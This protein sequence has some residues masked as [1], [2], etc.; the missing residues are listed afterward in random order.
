MTKIHETDKPMTHTNNHHVTEQLKSLSHHDFK[1]F[2]KGS[3]WYLLPI[4][5]ESDTIKQSNGLA[6][7]DAD[8]ERVNVFPDEKTALQT[9]WDNGITVVMTH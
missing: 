6:L 8:G 2:G 4:S 9:I 1:S 7:Y 3:I 5:F